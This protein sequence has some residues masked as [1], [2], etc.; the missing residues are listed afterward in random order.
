MTQGISNRVA[1]VGMGVVGIVRVHVLHE[2]EVAILGRGALVPRAQP[3]EGLVRHIRRVAVLGAGPDGTGHQGPVQVIQQT[4][5]P[6][7]ACDTIDPHQP[8]GLEVD[9]AREALAEVEVRRRDEVRHDAVRVV[10]G[11]R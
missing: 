9:V 4:V 3:S 2:Q 7:L 6:Q 10:A 11:H 1:V 8:M 5:E